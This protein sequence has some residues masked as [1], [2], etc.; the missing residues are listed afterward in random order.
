MVQMIGSDGSQEKCEEKEISDQ[1]I[2]L[3]S[4][5]A[6]LIEVHEHLGQIHKATEAERDHAR[7]EA[8][9]LTQELSTVQE[10][11]YQLQVCFIVTLVWQRR[12]EVAG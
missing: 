8:D 1:N 7:R 4:I 10:D 12:A 6:Q 5:N 3:A 11:R 2:R 9:D